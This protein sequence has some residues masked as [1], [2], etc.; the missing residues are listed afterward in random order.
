MPRGR[1]SATLTMLVTLSGFVAAGQKVT[2]PDEVVTVLVEGP[3]LALTGRYTVIA[4]A[5]PGFP[6]DFLPPGVQVKGAAT[7]DTFA[8][9]V[10]YVPASGDA[11]FVTDSR[12]LALVGWLPSGMPQQPARHGTGHLLPRH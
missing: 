10:A 2:L 9:L 1:V 11:A 6:Q 3:G 12:R 4:E 8:V 5:P 7:S